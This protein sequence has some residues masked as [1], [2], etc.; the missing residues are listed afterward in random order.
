MSLWIK[1]MEHT[2][3]QNETM[4]RVE[5]WGRA[6]NRH[7]SIHAI[8]VLN[9][10]HLCI[11]DLGI[12]CH[13]SS[14]ANACLDMFRFSLRKCSLTQFVSSLD[15][16]SCYMHM[17]FKTWFSDYLWLEMSVLFFVSCPLVANSCHRFAYISFCRDFLH[18]KGKKN[19]SFF[20]TKKNHTTVFLL[21][22]SLQQHNL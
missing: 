5:C 4:E 7:G 19:R 16:L 3:T 20:F 2:G 10:L 15:L 11:K 21:L 13:F 14:F 18:L 17:V 9:I 6:A 1:T 8:C 22:S 12:C